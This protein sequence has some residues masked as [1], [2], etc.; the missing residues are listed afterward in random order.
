MPVLFLFILGASALGGATIVML[1]GPTRTMVVFIEALWVFVMGRHM[2]H[3]VRQVPLLV[4]PLI[5]PIVLSF[6]SVGSP[7]WGTGL[8]HADALVLCVAIVVCTVI[9]LQLSYMRR[10]LFSSHMDTLIDVEHTTWIVTGLYA[11]TF[12]WL[13]S[14]ALVPGDAES[15]TLIAISVYLF[16]ASLMYS[17]AR[18]TGVFP[19]RS[20]LKRVMSL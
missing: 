18:V 8:I 17:V 1:D 3:T 13:L 15:G 16:V 7:A 9:A 14:H 11:I 4:A 20:W 2:F 5:V 19:R 12:V 10:S 6:S